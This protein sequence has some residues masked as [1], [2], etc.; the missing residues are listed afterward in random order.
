MAEGTPGVTAIV[1]SYNAREHLEG[2][3]EKLGA[4]LGAGDEIVV[5]DN[6]ST[7]G[8][9]ELV[10]R[11]FPHVRLIELPQNVGFGAA[12]NRGA[13]Q[14]RGEHLLL[15]NPDAWLA[16]GSLGKLRRALE[17]DR[18]LGL[19][20]PQLYYPDGRLQFTWAPETGVMGEAIQKARNRFEN[21]GWNHRL[22]PQLL[23]RLAGPG[24][25]TAA[26]VLVRRAAF[27]AIGG[28]DAE[29]FLY[30]EDVDL[31]RRFR[32]AGWKLELVA[33]ARAFHAK[34]GTQGGQPDELEYRRGQL[35]YYR[36]HRPH[37]EVRFLEGKLRRKFR[38]I[39]SPE[40]RARLL[41]LLE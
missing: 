18:G 13:E 3:L 11:R 37:W 32:L 6:A 20:A 29:I 27:E 28:F 33:E 41:A 31:C 22:L 19:A 23:R 14:A 21:Q 4:Q 10:A 40:L 26:C 39:G 2:C 5:V 12:N 17:G 7:D 36:K 25:L 15:L 30:F 9:P 16:E 1:V 35:R 34:G 8:S 24:W 38:R